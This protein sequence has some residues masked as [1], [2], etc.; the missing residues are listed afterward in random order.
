[1]VGIVVSRDVGVKVEVE[2]KLRLLLLS[3]LTLAIFGRIPLPYY[4]L[5][6]RLWFKLNCQVLCK[7]FAVKGINI[8][9][10][11]CRHKSGSQSLP[12]MTHPQPLIKL[13]RGM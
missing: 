2:A 8:I 10:E 4:S 13:M 11:S 5:V 6:S 3:D 7:W 12:E 9:K 1:M